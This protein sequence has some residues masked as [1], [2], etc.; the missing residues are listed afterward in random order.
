MLQLLNGNHAIVVLVQYLK[1]LLDG[2]FLLRCHDL[3]D[4]V[5]KN[6][7]LKS[8]V[9]LSNNKVTLKVERF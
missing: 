9:E 5:C 1:Q 6:D 3:R 8:I 2:L 7:S 4:Y